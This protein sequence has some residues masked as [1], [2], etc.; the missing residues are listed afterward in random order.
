VDLQNNFE[1]KTEKMLQYEIKN[2]YYYKLLKKI[3]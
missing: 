3:K 1:I 2:G